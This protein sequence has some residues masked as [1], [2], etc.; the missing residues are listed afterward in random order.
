[1]RYASWLFALCALV[2]FTA[3]TQGELQGSTQPLHL[4]LKEGPA[5]SPETVANVEQ[6][7]I[8][9]R[10]YSHTQNTPDPISTR[11][12]GDWKSMGTWES[13]ASLYDVTISDVVFNLW[14]VE[15]PNDENYEANLELRW[16][17]FLDGQ[18]I[19]QYE[20]NE[21]DNNGDDYEDGT[22]P[23]PQTRDDPCEY[24]EPPTG[25]FPNTLVERGL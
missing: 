2:V 16:T 5:F 15:D 18:Q 17:I 23:C 12:K 11:N 20:D 24:A 10:Y 19:F 22:G 4:N 21:D 1:M 25:T 3:G 8:E 7:A 14:W 13:D 6:E 9:E